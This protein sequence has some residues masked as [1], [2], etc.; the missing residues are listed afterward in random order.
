MAG[1]SISSGNRPDRLH[2]LAGGGPGV[3]L[4]IQ[5]VALAMGIALTRNIANT[6]D[7]LYSATQRVR[8]R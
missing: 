8:S 5:M 4:V 6:V 7:E 1:C 2:R 3:F